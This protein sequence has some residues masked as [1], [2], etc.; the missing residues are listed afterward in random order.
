MAYT[1]PTTVTSPR[2]HL[3]AVSIVHDTGPDGWS[4]ARLQWGHREPD[5]VPR[6][7]VGVRWNGGADYEGS[8][9]GP[10]GIPMWFVLP[11]ELGWFVAGAAELLESARRSR[12]G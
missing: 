2:E 4:V 9:R 11:D 1:D 12:E 6:T 8:P 3:H 10:G 7:R 5:G